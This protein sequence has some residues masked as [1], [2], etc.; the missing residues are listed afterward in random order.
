MRTPITRS[1]R[2]LLAA[3]PIVVA[4]ALLWQHLPDSTQVYGPFDVPGRFGAAASG[5][6]LTVTVDDVQLA[7]EVFGA[8]RMSTGPTVTAA[9]RWVVVSAT[10]SATLQSVLPS[11]ELRVGPNTYR[12]SDRFFAYTLSGR[13]DPGIS[14]R[15]NWVFDVPPELF[16]PPGA[17][18]FDLL[19]WPGL[20]DRLDNRLVINLRGHLTPQS[21]AI[22]LTAPELTG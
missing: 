7:T 15:G 16:D 11:V 21:T 5:R 12:P 4:A 6:A 3:A 1:R 9:G 8:A 14:Q 20:D 22:A 18:P 10:V 17:D 13:V 19:V 2:T